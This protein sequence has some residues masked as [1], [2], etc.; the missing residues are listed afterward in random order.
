MN[1]SELLQAV[2]NREYQK[3][4]KISPESREI[5]RKAIATQIEEFLNAGNI[6]TVLP[7]KFC[8]KNK[9]A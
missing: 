8:N 2:H 9:A 3:L 5:D 4:C 6:I 7:T 1:H